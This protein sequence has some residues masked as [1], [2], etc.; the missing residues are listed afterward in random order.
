MKLDYRNWREDRDSW[1]TLLGVSRTAIDLYLDCDVIDLHIEPFLWHRLIDYDMLERHGSG[2]FDGR[3]YSQTDLPR[4]REAQITGAT[5][6]ITTNP[7]RSSDGRAEAFSRNL[8]RLVQELARAPEDVAIVRNVKEYRA[9]RAK[10][11]HA[12]FI[13]IQGGNALDD[14]LDALDRMRDDLILRVTLVHLSSSRIGVTSSPAASLATGSDGLSRFGLDY[15]K[16]LNEKKVFVD[17]AHISKKGFWDALSVH[18]KSQP[19]LVTHT[20][21]SGVHEHWRNLDDEQIRAVAELGGVVGVMYHSSFLGDPFWGGK[22]ES[23]VRHL[24]HV[25]KVAGDNAPALGSDWDGMIVT[26]RDMPTCLELP[27]LV[28]AMLDRQWTHTR[29]RRVLGA[30][31]LDT[32]E[33]LRG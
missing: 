22:C 24:E 28:Q 32:V 9:A 3:F 25:A 2:L 1:A 31:F 11:L 33:R 18:D 14:N 30:N 10:G 20:G 5:W 6:V 26:P 27:R 4:L 23:I 13:G 29:I 17:L 15:V 19:V 8:D 16:R 12:A 7:F 21:V